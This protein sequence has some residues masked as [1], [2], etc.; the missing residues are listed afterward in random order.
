MKKSIKFIIP[1]TITAAMLGNIT[2]LAEGNNY[3]KD[4]IVYITLDQEGE[5]K[6]AYVVNSFNLE[7]EGNLVDYGE[8]IE[9]KNISTTDE[10]KYN[11]GEINANLPK[12]KFYY[13]GNLKDKNIPWNIN[14]NYKLDGKEISPTDLGGKSGKLEIELAVK[15]NP[16]I[17][18]T[19]FDNYALQ[20][21][22][23]LDTELC[24]NIV[25]EGGTLAN[26]G[27]T[28]SITYIKFPKEEKTYKI[29]ADVTNFEMDPISI[30]G[31]TMGMDVEID[32][33]DEIIDKMDKLS[34]G[35]NALD[36][37]AKSL[38]NGT[39][40]Y[41]KGIDE[42]SKK[43]GDLT[44]GV[45]DLNNGAKELQTG[46]GAIK[47]GISDLNN[48]A[49]N[50]VDGSNNFKKQLDN[51]AT[52]LNKLETIADSF[53]SVIP[54][55]QMKQIKAVIKGANDLATSYNQINNGI[56]NISAGAGTLNKSMDELQSGA[57]GLS[58]GT[59]ALNDATG[60]FKSGASA[61]SNGI[62][63]I[64]EGAKAIKSGTGELASKTG[65]IPDEVNKKID[66]MMEK[67]SN[68]DFKPKSFVSEKNT[69]IGAVQ[70]VIR[71]NAIEKKETVQE[72][73]EEKNN[74]TFIDR[75]KAI[76]KKQ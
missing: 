15:K 12:G 10:V 73:K 53:S 68:T 17:D 38:E 23:A 3:K 76:F 60:A 9:V 34:G 11:N 19:F 69:N 45:S 63:D 14:L 66:E 64:N 61:L 6:G 35:I 52:T 75:I 72:N 70:F 48:G 55:E 31:I 26:V 2:V 49:S 51:Y 27:S 47:K 46:I 56:G 57:K 62:K 40:E 4:E 30:N 67:Y 36:K 7:K 1:M 44:K 43:T 8:Y 21:S 71:T 33:K 13:E 65:D 18:E 29:T 28:K 24:K 32:G 37:G 59:N 50:L 54:A 5:T 42:L 74:E 41:K 20:I 25:A 39:N 22:M 58:A 16:N